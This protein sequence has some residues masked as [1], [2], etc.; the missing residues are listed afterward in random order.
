M[1]FPLFVI[2]FLMFVVPKSN[3]DC[4]LAEE[5]IKKTIEK[6]F[7]I[8]VQSIHKIDNFYEIIVN[9]NTKSFPIYADCML[10][11]IMVGELVEVESK[12]NITKLTLAKIK[13]KSHRNK[14]KQLL[15]FVSKSK[16]ESLSKVLNGK[17]DLI[18]VVKVDNI[19]KTLTFGVEKADKQIFVIS[20][21]LCPFCSKLHHNIKSLIS[22]GYNL[23]VNVIFYPLPIHPYAKE[24]SAAILC[25]QKPSMLDFIFQARNNLSAVKKLASI[26][27]N[28]GFD[29]LKTHV[30]FAKK[31]NV[32]GT[33]NILIPLKNNMFIKIPG[34]LSANVLKE[35]IEI[36]FA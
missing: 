22:N 3:A 34:A 5:Q 16:L 18:S 33:P 32:N 11:Y 28:K 13:A 25:Y 8:K 10:K 9:N 1:I 12:K 21:P 31:V 4:N 6:K 36:F 17:L 29:L 27:C 20:D 26:A 14:E 24:V 30:R 35:L 7:N 19:P 23:K 15:K 2:I